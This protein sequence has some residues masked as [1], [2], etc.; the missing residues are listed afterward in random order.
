MLWGRKGSLCKAVN[1]AHTLCATR[2]SCKALLFSQS[3]CGQCCCGVMQPAKPRAV[4]HAHRMNPSNFLRPSSSRA[5]PRPH[6]RLKRNHISTMWDNASGPSSRWTPLSGVARA[7]K[8]RVN[9][10][11]QLSRS[12][13]TSSL[14]AWAQMAEASIYQRSA[15]GQQNPEQVKRQCLSSHVADGPRFVWC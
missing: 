1:C 12:M 8:R 11:T 2:K 15:A 4:H 14:Q 7:S 5:P 3:G 9:V 10:R 13:R 6:M